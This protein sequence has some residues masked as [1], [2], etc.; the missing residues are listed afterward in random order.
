MEKRLVRGMMAGEFMI[1][2]H[3]QCLF[4][5]SRQ[6]IKRLISSPHTG[7]AKLHSLTLHFLRTGI[8]TDSYGKHNTQ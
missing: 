8:K 2:L 7:H 4:P 3:G 6:I 1:T 5:P